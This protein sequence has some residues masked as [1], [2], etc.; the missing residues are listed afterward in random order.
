M[1]KKLDRKF[2]VGA[3]KKLERELNDQVQQWLN[4]PESI[5][6]INDF[7]NEHVDSLKK[8]REYS[9][10]ITQQLNIP[11]KDDV[12]RIAKLIIQL[13][14]KIDA[15]DEQ[16][17]MIRQS[18]CNNS[19]RMKNMDASSPLLMVNPHVTDPRHFLYDLQK[20]IVQ[21]WE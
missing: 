13:E 20:M 8:L 21:E 18:S 5:R 4:N 2:I 12:A 19:K 14:E 15:L 10:F 11:T 6:D 9:E 7:M 3:G 16:V 1:K 17:Q